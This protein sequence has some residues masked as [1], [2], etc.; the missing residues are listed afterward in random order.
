MREGN[1]K[2]KQV[3][4]GKTRAVKQLSPNKEREKKNPNIVKTIKRSFPI[5]MIG[6]VKK[7]W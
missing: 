4:R 5:E 6:R 3:N 7:K 1:Q 2:S